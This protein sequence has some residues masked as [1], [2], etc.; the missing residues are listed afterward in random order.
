MFLQLPSIFKTTNA[1]LKSAGL[2]GFIFL[3]VLVSC[4]KNNDRAAVKEEQILVRVGNDVITV[5]EFRQNYETGFGH[6]KTGPDRKRTYLDYMIKERLLALEGYQLGLDKSDR[7][8]TL[9]RRLLNEL[10]IEALLVDEVRS[11]I[12]ITPEEIR[13]EINKSKVSFKFRY[14]IEDTNEKAKAISRDMRQR[15]YAEVVDDILSRDPEKRISPGKYETRYLTYLE[16]SPELLDAIK[17][18]PI[19]EISDPVPLHGKYYIFQVLDIRRSAVTENEYKSRAS[20]FEQIIF[21]RKYQEAIARYV[22]KLLEPRQVVTKGDAFHLLAKAIQEWQQ[23]DEKDRED[24]L[25]SVLKS[26]SRHPALKTLKDN[27][28]KPF[29]TYLEGRISLGDFLKEFNPAKLTRKENDRT[30]FYGRLGS[31]VKLAIRDHFLAEEAKK[32]NLQKDPEVQE[33]LTQWRNKW[34]FN[35]MRDYLTRDVKLTEDEIESY[36]ETHKVR[37]KTRRDAEPRLASFIKQARQDAHRDKVLQILNRKIEALKR[38]F[39]V[40]INQAILDTLH[41]VDFQ[42]SRWATFQVFQF[43]TNRPASPTVDPGWRD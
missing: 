27:L 14:W 20:S 1:R 19:G 31:A 15:G 3:F 17:D 25:E 28:D 5:E 30:D 40:V 36:F 38:K 39:P 37:Y 26:D 16:I 2:L 21:H 18:L 32:K 7:V 9:E 42:K 33:T 4:T 6:L 12:K 41:V 22:S 11:K 10:L 24:F 35:E 34:V 8:K 13:R 23:L 29:I 43:G